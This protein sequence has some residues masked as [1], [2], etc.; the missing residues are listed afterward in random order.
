MKYLQALVQVPTDTPPGNNAPHAERTKEL[1]AEMGLQADA[2][3]VPADEVKAYGLES[4]TN[5]I[6]R[7]RYGDGG[8][9]IALNAHGDVVPP[10]EGWTHGPYSGRDR[11]RQAVW[12]SQRRQQERFRDLY[13]RAARRWNRSAPS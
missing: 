9:V 12:P 6:V 11:R 2:Y 5:L 1:L 8:P 7:R 4:I 3:P 10:G 13:L